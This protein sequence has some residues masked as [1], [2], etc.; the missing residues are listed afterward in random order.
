LVAKG[1]H[2]VIEGLEGLLMPAQPVRQGT[3]L[4]Y[5]LADHTIV[6]ADIEAGTLITS[7]MLEY[8]EDAVLWK[9]RFEQDNKFLLG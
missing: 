2:H 3:Q 1:H 9:L 8:S 7:D 4:P 6:K 5:F